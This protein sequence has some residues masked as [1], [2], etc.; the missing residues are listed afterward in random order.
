LL[1]GGGRGRERGGE[2]RWAVSRGLDG[3][4]VAG[5]CCYEVVTLEG[6][7]GTEEEM[8]MLGTSGGQ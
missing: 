8:R 7:I 6:S 4:E 2:E 3:Q 1:S 5:P